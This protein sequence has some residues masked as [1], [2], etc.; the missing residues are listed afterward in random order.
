MAGISLPNPTAPFFTKKGW[1]FS[2]CFPVKL[3][4]IDWKPDQSHKHRNKYNGSLTLG[5]LLSDNV[6]GFFS[7]Y[8]P[9]IF[10]LLTCSFTFTA[11]GDGPRHFLRCL[12]CQQSLG[13]CRHCLTPFSKHLSSTCCRCQT[14]SWTLAVWGWTCQGRSYPP[15]GTLEVCCIS[16]L[17]EQSSKEQHSTCLLHP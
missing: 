14:L 11:L 5:R 16:H 7:S 9:Q 8:F 10:S 1:D 12:V 17:Q 15:A 13:K 3:Q 6:L 2:C 4:Y